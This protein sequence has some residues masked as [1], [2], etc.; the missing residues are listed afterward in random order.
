MGCN[1]KKKFKKMEKYSDD[2]N[3]NEERDVPSGVSKIL[4]HISRVVLQLFVGI[5]ALLVFI[6]AGPIMIIYVII[7]LII[8][9]QPS[10]RIKRFGR[11][12][13]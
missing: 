11:K 9:K 3:A 13:K 10:F 1:C 8:G 6:V 7:C 5:L 12:R 4:F 2:Y